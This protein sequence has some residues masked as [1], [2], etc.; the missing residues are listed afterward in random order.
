MNAIIYSASAS[1][2]AF[3]FLDSC[4]PLSLLSLQLLYIQHLKLSWLP[5]LTLQAV[6]INVDRAGFSQC[7]STVPSA[8]VPRIND[9]P[10]IPSAQFFFFSWKRLFHLPPVHVCCNKTLPFHINQTT[11]SVS[12]AQTCSPADIPFHCTSQRQRVI[13]ALTWVVSKNAVQ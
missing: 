12:W 8:I 3:I 6:L 9:A 7:L 11:L 5:L 1:S 10:V 2:W 4:L 13:H